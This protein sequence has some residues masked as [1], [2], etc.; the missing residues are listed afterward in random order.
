VRLDLALE[1][2]AKWGISGHGRLVR[3]WRALRDKFPVACFVSALVILHW[4]YCLFVYGVLVDRYKVLP[5]PLLRAAYGAANEL[6]VWIDVRLPQ[7]PETYSVSPEGG[8]SGPR[9][10]SGS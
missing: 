2:S 3:I 9:A 1:R 10:L 4:L 7:E 8:S 5:H 6:W